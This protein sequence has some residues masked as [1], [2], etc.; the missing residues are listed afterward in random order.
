M[1]H[2]SGEGAGRHAASQTPCAEAARG[3]GAW[4]GRLRD[5]WARA[6]RAGGARPL[7]ALVATLASE[8]ELLCR[9]VRALTC[10]CCLIP[11]ESVRISLVCC[12]T[13]PSLH[14]ST[15]PHIKAQTYHHNRM[16]VGLVSQSNTH[17]P[18][19]HSA[20]CAHGLVS[21]LAPHAIS[22]RT[23]RHSGRGR[24]SQGAGRIDG[25]GETCLLA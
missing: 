19:H 15:P 11:F 8:H 22:W 6:P 16:L 7:N 13:P 20:F 4:C 23:K 21:A 18:S 25:F 14:Y 3:G 10:V 12:F 9:C 5:C 2:V 17:M 24:L 1:D